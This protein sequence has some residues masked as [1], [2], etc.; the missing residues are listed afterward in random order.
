MRFQ[1]TKAPSPVLVFSGVLLKFQVG[2]L[3]G[4]VEISVAELLANGFVRLLGARPDRAP[5]S[6]G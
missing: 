6:E 5:A 3:K 2:V 1:G 4:V